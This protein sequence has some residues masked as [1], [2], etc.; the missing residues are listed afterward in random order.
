MTIVIPTMSPFPGCGAA[1]ED[2]I[3]KADT[4]MQQLPGVIAGM[5]ELGAAFNLGAG[6]LAGG[7]LPPVPYAAGINMTLAL[8]TVQRGE[9]TYAPLLD[10][11]A[12]RMHADLGVLFA[13]FASSWQAGDN[14]GQDPDHISPQGN[15]RLARVLSQAVPV[16][17]VRPNWV[18]DLGYRK[19]FSDFFPTAYA[20]LDYPNIPPGVAYDE[21][22]F[23]A[24][25]KPGKAVL[26]GRPVPNPGLS[27]DAWVES[28]NMVRL[29]LTN[30][31][32]VAID[33]AAATYQLTV[34]N[35]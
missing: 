17:K 8:Q 27:A 4:T 15:L 9:V 26:I 2:Y 23:V 30:L 22:V 19:V 7:Y 11:L 18:V 20:I 10:R 16:A 34:I 32:A 28:P 33:P 25:A 5:N 31:S 3:A 13:D 35:L 29:R 21:L 6:V 24:G 1:P 12:A 14:D